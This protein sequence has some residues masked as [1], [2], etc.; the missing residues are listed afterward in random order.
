ME[1]F[2]AVVYYNILN[3]Y[4]VPQAFTRETKN[5]FEILKTDGTETFCN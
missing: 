5:S 3:E 1:T 4:G 2:N